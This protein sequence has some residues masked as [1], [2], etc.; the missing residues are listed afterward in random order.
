MHG[1]PSRVEVGPSPEMRFPFFFDTGVPLVPT[2]E[3][4]DRSKKLIT[5]ADKLDW[6][7]M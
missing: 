5:G 1:E 6:K 4:V 7:G 3:R 2:P